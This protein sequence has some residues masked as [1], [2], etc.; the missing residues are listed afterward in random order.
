[1]YLDDLPGTLGEGGTEELRGPLRLTADFLL[2]ERCSQIP[3]RSPPGT[4]E[5]VLRTLD[6]NSPGSRKHGECLASRS[7]PL[8]RIHGLDE[9]LGPASPE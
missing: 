5:L 1:M 8:R 6:A 2:P 9:R 7:G 4:Q 3:H